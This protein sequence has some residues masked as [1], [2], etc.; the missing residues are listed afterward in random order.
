MMNGGFQPSPRKY[1]K[2]K[3]KKRQS[4]EKSSLRKSK[5][6]RDEERAREGKHQHM[7]SQRR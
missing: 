5:C 7:K 4:K 2:E 3:K 1:H 6:P